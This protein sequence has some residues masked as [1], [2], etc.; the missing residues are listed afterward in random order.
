MKTIFVISLF[1]TAVASSFAQAPDTLWTKMVGR[2][3]SLMGVHCVQQTSDGGYIA[4]GYIGEGQWSTN[5]T[6]IRLSSLGDV[7]WT[8]SYPTNEN[9]YVSLVS[10]VKQ[11][12]DRGFIACVSIC[13]YNP[14]QEWYLL[15]VRTDSLGGVLWQ[16]TYPGAV[17]DSDW[18]VCEVS[19][20]GFVVAGKG[21]PAIR[22]LNCNGDPVWS[23]NLEGSI[24]E[25]QPT[26]DGGYVVAGTN[27][28]F[29][30][31]KLD[32]VGQATW[33]RAY[34]GQGEQCFSVAQTLDGGYILGG[35]T[36]TYGGLY[37]DFWLVKTDQAGNMTWAR[38]Y[39]GDRYEQAWSVRQ[40]YDGGYV[41]TG[42]SNSF[43]TGADDVYTIKVDNSGNLI[44]SWILGGNR[45]DVGCSVEQT[46]DGGYI[47]A[48]YAESFGADWRNAYFIRFAPDSRAKAFVQVIDAG[49]PVWGYRLVHVQGTMNSLAFTNFCPGTIG[50]LS[51]SAATRW[52]MLPN[53]DSNNG[54]SIIFIASTPLTSGTIDTFWLSHPNCAAQV[55]WAV[56]DSNGTID[57]PLPVELLSLSAGV[58]PEG[59]ELQWN[60]ASET[61]NDFFEIMRGNSETGEF[62]R[63]ATL[64]SQGN[65]ATEHRYEYLDRDVTAGQTYWYY[66][67]D[68]DMS[69]TRTEHREMMRSA[70][71]TSAAELPSDYSLS[72][73]PNP[74]NPSTTISFSITEAGNVRMDVYDV[75][76]RWIRTLTDENREAG[77]YAVTFNANDLPSGIYFVRMEANAFHATRK[78][79]LMK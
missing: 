53:G 55:T 3:Y 24:K 28:G 76:G 37:I 4:S 75:S 23:R 63:I 62:S 56:G 20:G 18:S 26:T 22:K 1:L 69:G 21:T 30:L 66:L 77:S 79:V 68:V 78:V 71:M 43:G 47:V 35:S 8:R 29:F 16:R 44:W 45:H 33:T 34:G 73:Y 5:L 13:I 9:D 51:G 15:L 12:T 2:T 7:E 6:L 11:T 59:I 70:T 41:A 17:W 49:P 46:R 38:A 48:G 64:A 32:S 10:S 25:M 74:F 72:A 52:A 58:L 42:W 65:S 67:A 57:G 19:D 54:D 61:N 39:G 36:Y 31:T 14:A 60:T 40:T 50:S 27:N